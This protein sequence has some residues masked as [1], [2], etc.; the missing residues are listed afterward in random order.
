MS[1]K[2]AAVLA[3]IGQGLL[4]FMFVTNLINTV[5][6]VIR[7]LIPVMAMLTSLVYVLASLSL[8]VFFYV[9][10]KTQS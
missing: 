9:F 2:N 8:V 6:G 3:L 1:L 7:D 4:T 10:Y 5:L